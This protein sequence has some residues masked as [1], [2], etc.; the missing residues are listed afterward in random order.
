MRM[1][2]IVSFQRSNSSGLAKTAAGEPFFVIIT[3]SSVVLTVSTRLLSFIFASDRDKVFIIKRPPLKLTRIMV[4]IV[5]MGKI[6][7]LFVPVFLG[8]FVK[9]VKVVL[10]IFL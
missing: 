3:S 2:V 4:I 6:V 9:L 7:N 8:D 5:Q 1:Q 10:V